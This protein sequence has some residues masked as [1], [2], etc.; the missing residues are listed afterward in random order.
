MASSFAEAYTA[1]TD[2]FQQGT[3]AAQAQGRQALE[4]G[5]GVRA[6]YAA[7]LDVTRAARDDYAALRPPP[8]LTAHV[9]RLVD[10]LDRQTRVLKQVL[11]AI[12]AQDAGAV[13]APLQELAELLGEMVTAQQSIQQEVGTAV[14]TP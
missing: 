3:E 1:A 13:D 6:V 12:D 14:P 4:R 5:A 7:I 9:D 11:A 8:D 10:V 2:R